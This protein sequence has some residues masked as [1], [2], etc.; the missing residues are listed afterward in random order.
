MDCSSIFPQTILESQNHRTSV[1]GETCYRHSQSPSLCKWGNRAPECSG[2]KP[3]TGGGR[4]RARVVILTLFP[5]GTQMH[6]S[7]PLFYVSQPSIASVAPGQSF[8]YGMTSV[9][10]QRT[11]KQSGLPQALLRNHTRE[12]TYAW[13]LSCNL[14][15]AASVWKDVKIQTHSNLGQYICLVFSGSLLPTHSGLAVGKSLTNVYSTES[16]KEC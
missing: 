3:Q 6:I 9:D 8:A 10:F 7:G 1:L 16:F 12:H 4:D 2:Q 11:G 5:S 15:K 14:F 13:N